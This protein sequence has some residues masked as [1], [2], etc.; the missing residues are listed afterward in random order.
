MWCSFAQQ[1][2]LIPDEP[3]GV[4]NDPAS[5]HLP[6]WKCQDLFLIFPFLNPLLFPL[7]KA[8]FLISCTL[9]FVLF[10]SFFIPPL[11]KKRCLSCILLCLRICCLV[12]SS[13]RILPRGPDASVRGILREPP[14]PPVDNAQELH[15]STFFFFFYT[16]IPNYSTN[17]K[18]ISK[19]AKHGNSI[20]SNDFKFD[21]H[22]I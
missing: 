19:G 7:P 5:A 21:I 11:C 3:C 9:C 10:F 2:H 17:F 8:V 16:W 13:V 14:R 15:S 22:L 4:L 20:H 18:T 1:V 12:R 6:A